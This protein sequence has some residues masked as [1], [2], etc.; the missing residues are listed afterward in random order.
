MLNFLYSKLLSEWPQIRKNLKNMSG[1][2]SLHIL[3][4]LGL[5][6]QYFGRAVNIPVRIGSTRQPPEMSVLCGP[7]CTIV[8]G[9][10]A[11]IISLLVNYGNAL[12]NPR[13]ITTGRIRL[14]Y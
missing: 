2:Y 14:F 13:A 8:W 5:L 4:S 11:L 12:S 9:S 1:I 10:M 3:D 7:T 6:H